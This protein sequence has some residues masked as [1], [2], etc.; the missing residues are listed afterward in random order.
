MKI[1]SNRFLSIYIL[2][3]A[4]GFLPLYSCGGGGGSGSEGGSSS[5]SLLDSVTSVAHKNN[6]GTEISEAAE[7]NPSAGSVTQ[8]SSASNGVTT[9]RVSVRA[10]Y[11]GGQIQ[12]SVRNGSAGWSV[13]SAKDTVLAR[14]E[15]SNWAGVELRKRL[16][17]GDLYVDVYSEKRV[18]EKG[19]LVSGF[20]IYVP[21]SATDIDDLDLGVFGDGSDPFR[22]ESFSGLSG[23]VTYTGE[24][25]IMYSEEGSIYSAE[26]KVTLT[27]DFDRGTVRGRVHSFTDEDGYPI[28]GAVTLEET[29]IG[30]SNSGFFRGNTDLA[31]PP[32]IGEGRWGGQFF[33]NGNGI[34]RTAGGTFGITLAGGEVAALGVWGVFSPRTSRP[35]PSGGGSKCGTGVADGNSCTVRTDNHTITLNP[36]GSCQLGSSIRSGGGNININGV[37]ICEQAADNAG[38]DWTPG[39]GFGGGNSGSVPPDPRPD[40][41]EKIP[42]QPRLGDHGFSNPSLVA[43]E[44]TSIFTMYSR[45]PEATYYK[46]H[47]NVGVSPSSFSFRRSGSGCDVL[48]TAD[49]VGRTS[50]TFYTYRFRAP[51]LPGA[52]LRY[53][54][55]VQAC[56]AAGCSCPE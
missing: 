7:N 33:G 52:R 53:I 36:D 56:N 26:G 6:A 24:A 41:S 19:S 23:T 45:V 12:Y 55:T 11:S 17:N 9:D 2:A 37:N 10:S 25:A 32:G 8:S 20:W 43:G 50:S 47:I 15:A 14:H 42:S 51:D 22:Q 54:W 34:P 35:R 30:T 46:V 27:V 1:V 5:Q 18:E 29:D 49:H 40:T 44:L 38:I 48:P 39:S 21:D 31:E 28:E 13:D 4:L 3:L 16:L